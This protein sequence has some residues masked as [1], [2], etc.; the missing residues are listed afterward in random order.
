MR[1][2]TTGGSSPKRYGFGY[3]SDSNEKIDSGMTRGHSGCVANGGEVLSKSLR[4]RV[5]R[6]ESDEWAALP[7]GISKSAR[8]LLRR[9]EADVPGKGGEE[10]GN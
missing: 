2:Q 6:R 4:L 10:I 9:T 7:E 5:A 8:S 1:S 3:P